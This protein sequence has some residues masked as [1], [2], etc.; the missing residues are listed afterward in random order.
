MAVTAATLTTTVSESINLNGSTYAVKE[1][2][3]KLL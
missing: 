2:L 1:I 3:K